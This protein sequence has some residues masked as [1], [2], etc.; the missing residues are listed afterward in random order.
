MRRGGE[1]RGGKREE[2]KGTKRR[3]RW[4]ERRE[5]VDRRRKRSEWKQTKRK[6]GVGVTDREEE[7]GKV[8]KKKAWMDREKTGKIQGKRDE[9]TN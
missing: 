6:R 8:G 4:R 9:E 5:N 2:R 3:E 7:K 1:Q